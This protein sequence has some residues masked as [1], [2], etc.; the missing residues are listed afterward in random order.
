MENK[1]INGHTLV[2]TLN[3]NNSFENITVLDEILNFIADLSDV[4]INTLNSIK[5]NLTKFGISVSKNK[6][7]FVL[8]SKYSFDDTLN[9][10]PTLQEAQDF[11]E[12]EEIERQ[13]DF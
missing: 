2:F 8:V 5:N 12:M 4:D 11:I 9:I 1:I 13:L 3:G 7:T 10:V 6:G